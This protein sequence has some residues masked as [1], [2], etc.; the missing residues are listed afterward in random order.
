ME[1]TTPP[2][3]SLDATRV[4]SIQAEIVARLQEAF[5]G[6]DYRRGVIHDRV[7]HLAAI[8]AAA[9]RSVIDVVNN[10]KSLLDIQSDPGSADPSMVD[11]VLSNFRVA[12]RPGGTASGAAT[13][14]VTARSPLTVAAGATF[15]SGGVAFRTAAATAVRVSATQVTSASDRVLTPLPDGTY[16]FSLPLVA[17]EAGSAGMIRRGATLVPDQPPPYFSSAYAETDFAGGADLETNA[18][19]IARLQSGIAAP[20]WSNRAN[21]L[22]MLTARDEFADLAAL[23]LIGAG[24]P[25][26]RRSLRGP[27]PVA[28]AGF[29]DLY[30][31]TAALPARVVLAK[32][33]TLVGRDSRGGIWQFSLGR[34]DAPGFYE[35]SQI[36]RVGDAPDLPGYEVVSDARGVDLSGDAY[37]PDAP[38]PADAAYSRYQTAVIRFVDTDTPAGSL[39]IGAARRT[40]AVAVSAMPKLADLQSFL[41]GR[42]TRTP[43]LDLVVKGAVPCSLRVGVTVHVPPGS[44]VDAGAIARRLAATVNSSGFAGRLYASTLNDAIAGLLPEG[45][46]CGAYDLFGRIRRPD[47]SIRFLRQSTVLEIP[48][49][50]GGG[51]TPRTTLFF[52][53]PADV[54]VAASPRPSPDI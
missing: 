7:L 52:L 48:D 51:V 32:E 13:V 31:R 8:L 11:A 9:G 39:E 35:V 42:S 22:A 54:S 25:E 15:S 36:L 18:Q 44:T 34:D 19:L 16:A 12:R 29:C 10:S 40:Y 43:G 24:D 5:P 3:L 47:G 50:P 4:A 49:D 23:S 53:D 21:V 17:A 41:N 33:A 28:R 1:E 14:I 20:V 30:A 6:L 27:L 46:A 2:L 26:M 38:A 45:A 37:A